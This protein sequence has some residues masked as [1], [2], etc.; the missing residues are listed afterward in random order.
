MLDNVRADLARFGEGWRPRVRGLLSQGFQ[1]IVV[2]RFFHACRK[3]GIPTQPFRFIVERFIEIT[4][5]IQIP[6]SC[7]IGPGLRIHH[8]GGI[9][10]HPSVKLGEGCTLYQGVT[11]GD[12]GGSGDA[13]EVGD[14]VTFGAGA[15]ITGEIVIGDDCFVGANAVVRESV[16]AGHIAV[17]NPAVVKQRKP[18][19]EAS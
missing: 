4:T 15:V 14:R 3:A 10:F 2:Y 13:A 16:P 8:F 6:A 11:I 18:R 9:I 1:A 12:R 5:G 17:G 7:Q 19:I